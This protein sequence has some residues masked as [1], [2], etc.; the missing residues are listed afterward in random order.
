MGNPGQLF[1]Y[2]E[3]KA[4]SEEQGEQLKNDAIDA[5]KAESSKDISRVII[6]VRAKP[7]D[8]PPR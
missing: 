3:L 1:K 8:A 4:L 6:V 2:T 7:G 5:I